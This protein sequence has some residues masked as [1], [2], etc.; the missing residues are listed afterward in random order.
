[1]DLKK[2]K[3]NDVPEI[4]K[5]QAGFLKP[6]DILGEPI[7]IGNVDSFKTKSGL[8]GVE[9]DVRLLEKDD[10]IERIRS[11][12]KVLPSKLMNIKKFP[13]KTKIVLRRS[14]SGFEYHDLL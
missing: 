7:L 9:F 3:V 2:F 13:V 5:Q 10:R 11:Y 6:K 12:G 8:E 1:M 4:E 14:K